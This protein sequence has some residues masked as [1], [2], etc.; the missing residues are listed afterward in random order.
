MAEFIEIELIA[1]RNSGERFE[2]R[3]DGNSAFMVIN[4]LNTQCQLAILATIG[5]CITWASI[6]GEVAIS[7]A[8]IVA[9]SCEEI[10]SGRLWSNERN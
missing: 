6:G 3:I 10:S 7:E 1:R 5:V 9:I 8:D 4:I 2:I